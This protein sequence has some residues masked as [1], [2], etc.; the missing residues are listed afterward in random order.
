MEIGSFFHVA[1]K[2]DDLAASEAFYRERFGG[3]VVGRG[4]ATRGRARRR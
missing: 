4:N 1:V 2:T 3:E